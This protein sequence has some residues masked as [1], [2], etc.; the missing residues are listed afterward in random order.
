[1][2]HTLL[3]IK[4]AA[5]L[6][7]TS[8]SNSVFAQSAKEAYKTGD[9]S[10]AFKQWSIEAKN[11]NAAAQFNL[12]FMYENGEA[13]K[14]DLFAAAKWYELA[15]GQNYPT[16]KTMLTSV[17]KKIETENAQALLNWLPQADAGDANSQLAVSKVLSSGKLASQ[18]NIEAYKWLM[19]AEEG[20]TNT[21]FKT[22]IKRY[23]A[24]LKTQLKTNDI[25]EA[26]KRVETWKN[27]REPAQ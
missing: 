11:G 14:R 16:S 24:H 26:K 27:L 20:A 5:I 8:L 17:R 22:R 6:I 2:K 3:A 7:A 13:T 4:I 10:S 19:L 9:H 18:D 25:E 15:A 1:M 12:A 21:T 23:K